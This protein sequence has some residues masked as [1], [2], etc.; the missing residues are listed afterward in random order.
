MVSSRSIDCAYVALPHFQ[1]SDIV[2]KL[3]SS[4][5]HVIKEKPAAMTAAELETFQDLAKSNSVTFNTASQFRYSEQVQQMKE[6]LPLI[7]K[8]RFAEGINTL[9]VPD[10]GAGWRASKV[11]SGGGVLIDLGWHLVDLVLTLL[12]DGTIPV[13]E[14]AK[15]SQTRLLQAYDCEDTTRAVLNI[16]NSKL[17]AVN[18]TITC[19]IFMTRLGPTKM[20]QLTVYG[21]SGSIRLENDFV[22]LKLTDRSEKMEF[23]GSPSSF[24]HMMRKFHT[25]VSKPPQARE[26]HSQSCHDLVTM[27]TIDNIYSAGGAC[28]PT[29]ANDDKVRISSD[30]HSARDLSFHWPPVDETSLRAV[31]D[32]MKESVSIYDNGGIFGKFEEAWREYH[33]TPDSFALLHNSGTNALQSLYF[34]AQLQPGDEVIFPVYSF[35]A[36]SSPA[37]QFGVI[38]V[39]CDASDDGNISPEAIQSSITSRTKAVVVTHM[40]GIP[41]NMK[42]ICRIL[43]QYPDIM[44]LEDC[45]HAHGA[46]IEGQLVGTFGDAAAWSL[47]GQ[48]IISGGEGGITLTKDS[49]IFHRQLIWGH[50]N[51][52]CKAEIPGDHPL[53]SFSL[54]GAG[55]KNRAHPLGVA[56]AYTQL[57]RLDSIL[58]F[59]ALYA[60]Q[61]ASR[62]RSIPFLKVPDIASLGEGQT[63]PAWYAF[64]FRFIASQAPDGLSR[65]SFVDALHERGLCEVDIPKSTGLLHQEP[66]YTT[67]HELFPHLYAKDST[68][69][70]QKDIDFPVAQSF[71]DE[72]IKLPV[73]T[74]RSDQ[75]VVDHYMDVI[76]DVARTKLGCSSET[77]MSSLRPSSG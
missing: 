22:E 58:R 59:K 6:W 23:E 31:R 68:E 71:Y 39:F 24:E 49:N 29:V 4:K 46:K 7:G 13:T 67:P 64:V 45:S 43:E 34:A 65:E 25:R 38:P 16:H 42:E 73:W 52:R 28:R 50:Y 69:S 32:Q 18:D 17:A 10:L 35:H 61:M 41:C 62:L 48:K 55:A 30:T 8:V 76:C 60:F 5:I 21:E 53:R 63:E 14:Y 47:Q 44:L 57:R 37:M 33:G 77:E 20:S 3:L 15:L 26:S 72:A 27:R 75:A 74:A 11:L 12:G 36:T 56:L 66:L 40:W 51:K 54:T 2:K 9:S 1:S 70:L 19:N